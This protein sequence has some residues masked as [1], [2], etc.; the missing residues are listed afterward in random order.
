MRNFKKITQVFQQP[1]SF[2]IK[3]NLKNLGMVLLLRA[4]GIRKCFYRLH[5]LMFSW[6]TCV[7]LRMVE[8]REFS[9]LQEKKNNS[10]LQYAAMF[11][12]E[13]IY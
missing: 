1:Y 3:A 4:R 5:F 11:I 7:C 8:D 12:K 9:A 13:T 10:I 2:N 6:D